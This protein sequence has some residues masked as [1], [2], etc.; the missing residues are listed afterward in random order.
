MFALEIAS[1]KTVTVDV[2]KQPAK[3]AELGVHE[4]WC[5]DPTGGELLDPPL[6]GKRRR[7]GRWEPIDVTTGVD[8]ALRGHSSALGL[9][10]CWQPPNLRPFDPA[11]GTWLLDHDDFLEAK[12][13]TET[14]AAHEAA[15]R[16]AAEA[17][18]AALCADLSNPQTPRSQDE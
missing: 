4:Y 10:L 13:A 7:G 1:P 15:A 17:K 6:Q 16:K 18:L 3:Y 2:H 12:R 9:D 14:R 11:A 5:L 8:D